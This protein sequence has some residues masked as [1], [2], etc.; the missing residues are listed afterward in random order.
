MSA[1]VDALN[2]VCPYYTMYPLE[3]PLNVL[4]RHGQRGEWVLDP[5]CGRGT[6]NFAARLLGMPSF[7][8]DSS[9][10]AAALAQAKLVYATP[11]RVVASARAILNEGSPSPVPSGE[12][13]KWAYHADTL[14][15]LCCLRDALLKACSTDSRLLLRAILLGALHGP[16]PKGQPSYFSN[17]APRTFAPKPRYAVNFWRARNLR[18]KKVDVLKLVRTRARRTPR[19]RRSESQWTLGARKTLNSLPSRRTMMSCGALWRT[20]QP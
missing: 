1:S 13:W 8:I 12:F 15:D 19:Q 16:Q 10:V 14:A 20:L 18:P 3:F 4:E 5:F 17:Q 2:A 9:P 6:T 11:G 7:G